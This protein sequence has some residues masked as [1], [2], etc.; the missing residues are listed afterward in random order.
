MAGGGQAGEV[1]HRGA[2]GEPDGGAGRQAERLEHP[3]LRD[4]LDRGRGGRADAAERVLVPGRDQPVGAERRRQGAAGHEAEVARSRVGDRGRPGDA[5]EPLEDGDRVVAVLGQRLVE[6]GDDV[7]VG[8]VRPHGPVGQRGE[9]LLGELGGAAQRR[10]SRALKN[11]SAVL[12][13][14]LLLAVEVDA[15]LREE[16]PRLGGDLE[17]LAAAGTWSTARGCASRPGRATAR[18]RAGGRGPRGVN[19]SLSTVIGPR[20]ARSS[21]SRPSGA[22]SAKKARCSLVNSL[23]IGARA[24]RR[25]SA[26]VGRSSIAP[27]STPS[28]RTRPASRRPRPRSPAMRRSSSGSSSG[29]TGRSLT[30]VSSPL[31]WTRRARTTT[32]ALVEVEV[33]RVEEEDLADLGVERVHP[34]RGHGGALVVL[35]H[36]QLQ[37]DRV[38][39][40]DQPH[41]V[42]QLVVCDGGGHAPSL[43]HARANRKRAK[44]G[45]GR[46]EGGPVRAA[47]ACRGH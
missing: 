40:A 2:R 9:V 3:A 15:A 20:T 34:Q 26:H 31:R 32:P 4:G 39:P 22:C 46:P 5:H 11:S 30:T 43:T 8:Q 38:G 37:L 23:R 12:G 10:H 6:R 25:T 44:P 16:G 17:G 41:Q 19:L 14:R 27:S 36:G 21:S 29:T 35:G 24:R 47:A 28:R 7:V 1:G 13:L 45:Y 33:G 42:G 18:R